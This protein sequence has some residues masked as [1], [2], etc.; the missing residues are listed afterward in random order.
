MSQNVICWLY[1]YTD[2]TIDGIIIIKKNSSNDNKY[3][4]YHAIDNKNDNIDSIKN[5]IEKEPEEP[6]EQYSQENLKKLINHIQGGL[7]Q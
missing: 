3:M 5:L 6:K 7:Y 2:E 1:T 4:L